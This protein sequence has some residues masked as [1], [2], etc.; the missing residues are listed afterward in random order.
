MWRTLTSSGHS[1]ILLC[2]KTMWWLIFVLWIT[3]AAAMTIN[4]LLRLQMDYYWLPVIY[5]PHPWIETMVGRERMDELSRSM[6]Q[7]R[8]FRIDLLKS[9]YNW[10]LLWSI[11]YHRGWRQDILLFN[12]FYC[13][14]SFIRSL[15]SMSHSYESWPLIHFHWNYSLHILLNWRTLDNGHCCFMPELVIPRIIG[16]TNFSLYGMDK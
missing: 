8:I 10:I 1:I 3:S 9:S 13:Y 11:S 14:R 7:C 16:K 6:L 4:S 5:S 15:V 12:S 2:R